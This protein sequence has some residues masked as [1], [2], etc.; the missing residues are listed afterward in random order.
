MGMTGH[1]AQIRDAKERADP[2]I[3]N[4]SRRLRIANGLGRHGVRGQPAGRALLRSPQDDVVHA[5]GM[6]MTGHRAQIRDAKEPGIFAEIPGAAAP[7]LAARSAADLHHRRVV[8]ARKPMPC[9]PATDRPDSR[10]HDD[11]RRPLTKRSSAGIFAEIPG[12]AAPILAARSAA[13]LH[14]RRVV[15]ARKPAFAAGAPTPPGA[16]AFPPA[17][18]LPPMA[19]L[20]M[21]AARSC[22]S[23]CRRCR[24]YRLPRCWEN[25]CPPGHPRLR[26][27]RPHTAGGL[28]VPAGTAVTSYGC[29]A[30]G[31]GA[32]RIR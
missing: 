10:R 5:R 6:G 32:G 7:I 30:D 4:A 8:D 17:P 25:W 19:A 18:P 27:R 9:R 12:A 3:I 20:P 23:R 21:E 2:K 15:D 24:R 28:G 16:W 22:R 31:S 1:R 14:H 13:D 26:R 11:P 29:I